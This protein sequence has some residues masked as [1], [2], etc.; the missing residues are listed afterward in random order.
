MICILTIVQMDEE[1]SMATEYLDVTEDL[2]SL[3]LKKAA[4]VEGASD[5]FED[6]VKQVQKR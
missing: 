1:V 3:W 6:Y 2:A 4:N 5:Q